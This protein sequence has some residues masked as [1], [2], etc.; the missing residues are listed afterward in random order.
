MKPTK[1]QKARRHTSFKFTYEGRKSWFYLCDD[2]ASFHQPNTSGQHNVFGLPVK[3][4][5]NALKKCGY[6]ALFLCLPAVVE[7][8]EFQTLASTELGKADLKV[9]GSVHV[10][11]EK[12]GCVK[13]IKDGETVVR[14]TCR[15][16]K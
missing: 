1:V 2:L 11:S 10:V 13:Y 6:I 8:A 15:T 7:A 16:P 12:N 5:I 14:E 3:T 9:G 4:L